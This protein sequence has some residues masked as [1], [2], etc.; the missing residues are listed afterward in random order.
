MRDTIGFRIDFDI[1][2]ISQITHLIGELD[3][4]DEEGERDYTYR[5]DYILR[6]DERLEIC[7]LLGN[8]EGNDFTSISNCL[9]DQD[10]DQMIDMDIENKQL[11]GA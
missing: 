8:K 2:S 9:E 3:Y 6:N 1:Q 5:L 10:W 11:K 7:E 4:T